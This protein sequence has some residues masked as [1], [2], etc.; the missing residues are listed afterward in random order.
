MATVK[1]GHASCDERG[2]ASGGQAGDQTGQEVCVRDWYAGGWNV[3][4]R[5]R[6]AAVAEKMAAFCE[7]VCGNPKVGYDQGRRNTLRQAAL[8]ADW[9]G[10]KIATACDTD[11]SAFMC[12]CAE[13]AGLNVPYIYGNAPT[14]WTMRRAFSST[15]AFEVLTDSKYLVSDKYLKRG[16]VLLRE[17]GHTAMALDNGENVI[18]TAAAEP[19]PR[20]TY[21]VGSGDTLWGI[22]QKYGVTLADLC[23]ANG[24]DPAKYIWP[25]QKLIIPN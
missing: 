8:M 25:G 21:V 14:T 9:D 13:A 10:A 15:G 5:P 16:D 7:A 24:I 19:E 12:V 23:A 6:S 4:L 11:C 17:S 3:V 1:I 2:K 22:S 18:P 20:K